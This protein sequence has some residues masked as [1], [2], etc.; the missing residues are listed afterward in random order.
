MT[1]S[2]RT[3]L[4]V[5]I[6][7]ANA[8]YAQR[9]APNSSPAQPGTGQKVSLDLA[10]AKGFAARNNYALQAQRKGLEEL[11]ARA[12]RTN[13]PFLP[14]LDAVGG[15]EGRIG[16][17]AGMTPLAYLD[18]SYVLFN[19]TLDVT[20]RGVATEEVERARA[21]LVDAEFSVGLEVEDSFATYL[22]KKA[23]IDLKEA[24]IASN[25]AHSD[26]VRQLR[27]RGSASDSD[28]M[29]FQ[30]KASILNSDLVALKQA[31]EDAR[32]NL[33]RL[34]GEE[35]GQDI[36]PTGILRHQHVK[37][38]LMDV[39]V[40]LQAASNDLKQRASALRSA[41]LERDAAG[42]RW[43]P[44]VGVQA[45]AGLLPESNGKPGGK[46]E[47]SAR[48]E[49]F[50][51]GDAR[52]EASEKTAAAVKSEALLKDGIA[53]AVRAAEVRYRTL[54]ML[55]ARADLEKDNVSFARRYYDSVLAEYKRGYK[56][57]PDLDGALEKLAG[58]EERKLA[59]DYD[60]VRGRIELERLVGAPVEVENGHLGEAK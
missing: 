32:S 59:L 13:A 26:L 8:A 18:A 29:E 52:W 38:K 47:L 4:L 17:A 45:R 27:A 55:E 19:R 54:R 34:L 50:A 11:E 23:Q 5:M 2:E 42:S 35:I 10:L 21:G 24:E 56:N 43:L 16:P 28:L 25:R 3:L 39:I 48:M 44:T 15:I 60:F 57:S 40:L 31:L 22:Y 33:K 49:L 12:A 51:G 37:P 14:K 20:R 46:I 58:A 6:L 41:R 7:S 30:L 53:V 9:Q 1:K 36:E